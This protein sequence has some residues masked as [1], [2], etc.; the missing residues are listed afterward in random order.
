MFLTST[1]S[2]MLD[3]QTFAYGKRLDPASLKEKNDTC[4]AFRRD[5]KTENKSPSFADPTSLLRATKDRATKGA[6]DSHNSFRE[7]CRRIS[8]PRL[9]TL[10][11]FHLVPIN[12]VISHEPDNDS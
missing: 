2:V 1:L 9:N 12:V 6:R 5:R 7:F 8:T 10:L 4:L 3:T 11:C